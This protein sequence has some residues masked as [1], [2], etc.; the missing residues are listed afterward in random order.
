MALDGVRNVKQTRRE[1]AGSGKKTKDTMD[2]IGAAGADMPSVAISYGSQRS[3][4]SSQVD[5]TSERGSTLHAAGDLT[6]NATGGDLV[7]IGSALS[8]GGTATLAAQRNVALLTSADTQS[9]SSQSTHHSK[10]FTAAAVGWGDAARSL[11]GGANSS[12]VSMSPYNSQSGITQN[13]QQVV[14][15]TGTRVDAGQISVISRQGDI[16]AE[17]AQLTAQ[18][19]I[20]GWPRKARSTWAPP[21]PASSS[22][23]TNAA[24]RSATWAATATPAPSASGRS[25]MTRAARK[26]GKA[27]CAPG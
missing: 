17:G 22:K 23:P 10:S 11:Q 14:N 16:T 13:A 21:S 27:R 7:V 18:H 2:A 3:N 19:D 25:C 20:N 24:I 15:E 8:A 6:L 5:T 26:P 1:E 4:Q 12:G 9:Q